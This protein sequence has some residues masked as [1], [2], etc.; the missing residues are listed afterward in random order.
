M[1]L[2][3]VVLQSD[4]YRTTTL[5]YFQ[6]AELGQRFLYWE[7]MFAGLLSAEVGEELETTRK[8]EPCSHMLFLCGLWLKCKWFSSTQVKQPNTEECTQKEEENH[9][10]GSFYIFYLVT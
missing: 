9:N 1:L 7:E 8:A 5:F 6:L 3:S 2:G 4:F 10:T